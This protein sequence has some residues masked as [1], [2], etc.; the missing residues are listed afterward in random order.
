MDSL[1]PRKQASKLIYTNHI[2]NQESRIKNLFVIK[3]LRDHNISRGA[4]TGVMAPTKITKNAKKTKQKYYSNLKIKYR[5]SRLATIPK[6]K[7]S[8]QIASCRDRVTY[9]TPFHS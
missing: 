2:K 7:W 5:V 6:S 8:K 1:I 4:I 9:N 3:P